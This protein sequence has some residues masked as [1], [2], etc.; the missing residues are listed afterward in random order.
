MVVQA[1][2]VLNSWPHQ[3]AAVSDGHIQWIAA[4]YKVS[5]AQ[6]LVRWT[7]Q[8]PDTAVLVR[9]S[10]R[11][12]LL[13][14]LDVFGFEISGD[15]MMLID[16]LNTMFSPFDVQWAQDVYGQVSNRPDMRRRQKDDL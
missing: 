6:L 11:D 10:D 2:C 4:K 9:S 15:D 1:Y 7:L 8:H 14:N 5:A 13:Q 12:H 3:V 16:G